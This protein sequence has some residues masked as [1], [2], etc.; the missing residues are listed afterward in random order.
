[1]PYIRPDR[2]AMIARGEGPLTAG[3][4]NYAI[5]LLCASYLDRGQDNY[6]AR[7]DIVGAL[8]LAKVEFI[9]RKVNNYEDFKIEE[10]GDVY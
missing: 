4:L 1:M 6:Q 3:E 5:T 10:N 2:R 7:N 9:R 8:E